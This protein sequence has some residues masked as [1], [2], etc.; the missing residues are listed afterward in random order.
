MPPVY[1]PP[2]TGGQRPEGG[3]TDTGGSRETILVDTD[4]DGVGDQWFTGD[5]IT[6]PRPQTPLEDIQRNPPPVEQGLNNNNQGN[7][8]QGNVGPPE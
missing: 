3:W 7:A 2:Q 8:S 4:G 1:I 6:G 5:V